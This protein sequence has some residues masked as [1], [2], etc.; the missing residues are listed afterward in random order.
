MVSPANAA[1]A[2]A[3]RMAAKE[4][5]VRRRQSFKRMLLEGKGTNPLAS[6]ISLEA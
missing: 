5:R 6:I 4:R 1:V 3:K 2:V